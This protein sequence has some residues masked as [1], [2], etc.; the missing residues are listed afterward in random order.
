MGALVIDK[1]RA[2][3]EVH[4]D[5][6]TATEIADALLQRAD[7]PFRMGHHFASE[8]TDFGRAHRL[9]M[10]AIPYRDAARIYEAIASQ[11][12]PL[13]EEAFAEVSSPEY[14]VF[15]RKGMGGS[16]IV[17]VERMLS[18]QHAEV[19]ADLAWIDLQRA[20]LSQADADLDAAAL[21][22]ARRGT[23]LEQFI[24]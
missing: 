4:S 23:A 14:M 13:D 6:S 22:I 9:E 16:Q 20:H 5:Y 8:L 11:P 18:R 7:V 24:H 1:E 3:A 10:R 21:A 15:G 17:E 19:A 12:F 2:L